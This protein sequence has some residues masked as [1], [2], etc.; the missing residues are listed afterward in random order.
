MERAIT[1]YRDV[2]G[3]PLLRQGERWA[4]LDASGGALF[5][6]FS[7]GTAASALKTLAQQPLRVAF[8]VDNLDNAI[9]E[10]KSKGINF[11]GEIGQFGTERWAH[12]GDPEGNR[13]EI[14][15]IRP[16]K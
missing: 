3:F 1:F 10:L 13:L 7:G 15:E 11:I 9:E 5:E 12:F 14:K 4:H 16:D 8:L 6:L 2:I